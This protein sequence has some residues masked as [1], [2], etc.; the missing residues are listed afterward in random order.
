MHA[1]RFCRVYGDKID[2]KIFRYFVLWGLGRKMEATMNY[3]RKLWH[4]FLLHELRQEYSNT[5]WKWQG[6]CPAR[7]EVR[8]VQV[9]REKHRSCCD[10]QAPGIVLDVLWGQVVESLSSKNGACSSTEREGCGEILSPLHV[11][12]CCELRVWPTFALSTVP[13]LGRIKGGRGGGQHD[14]RNRFDVC[15]VLEHHSAQSLQ[16]VFENPAGT[17]T[18]S[19]WFFDGCS[20][21]H[22]GRSF[23]LCAR[24]G[25]VDWGGNPIFHKLQ[26]HCG[27]SMASAFGKAQPDPYVRLLCMLSCWI[28]VDIIGCDVPWEGG[29]SVSLGPPHCC[30]SFASVG[31]AHQLANA[32]TWWLL[33]SRANVAETGREGSKTCRGAAPIGREAEGA[34]QEGW[35]RWWFRWFWRGRGRWHLWEGEQ[36]KRFSAERFSE[37]RFWSWR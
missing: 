10:I 34:R 15:K 31:D 27:S 25:H 33:G 2:G 5:F 14:S 11:L 35:W 37:Q 32:A 19:C 26:C 36:E 4:V 20:C 29:V 23:P 9:L 21:E 17:A 28:F 12:H 3:C 18:A 30:D 8:K 6:R 22:G 7:C 24:G 1:W 13:S 16:Q